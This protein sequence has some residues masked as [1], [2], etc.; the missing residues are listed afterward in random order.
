MSLQAITISPAFEVFFFF[1]NFSFICFFLTVFFFPVFVGPFD[2]FTRIT[3]ILPLTGLQ[4]SEKVSENCVAIWKSIGIYTD[5]EEKAIQ[6]FLEVFKDENFPPG[7]SVLFTQSP[8]GSLAV[9]VG[10]YFNAI[11][12]FI[13]F[14]LLLLSDA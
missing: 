1:F 10:K 5:A 11:E 6:K 7:S 4:Y 9:S 3:M 12:S 13:C 2:K 14:C 8:T